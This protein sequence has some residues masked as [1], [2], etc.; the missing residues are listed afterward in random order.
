M[1]NRREFCGSSPSSR[2]GRGQAARAL[3]A[4]SIR[5]EKIAHGI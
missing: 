5:Y 2:G 4:H 3:D 1:Y